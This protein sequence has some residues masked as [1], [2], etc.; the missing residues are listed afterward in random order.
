MK[1]ILII[2]SSPRQNGNCDI[3]CSEFG[4]GA[5]LNEGNEVQR[6][7]LRDL[8][9][10]F[11]REEQD[12]DDFDQVAQMMIDSDV[13]ALASPV[14]FY[15]MS[16]QMKT[17]MD[18]MMPYFS[19]VSDKDFYFILT[20]AIN[21]KEMQSAIDAMSGFTDSLPNANIVKVFLA[22]NISQKGEVMEKPVYREVFDAA[23]RIQ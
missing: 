20:S 16:G 13:I 23:A 17:M 9:Y 5:L 4:R 11:Y 15:T 12:K 10:D 7:D 3:L 18:R 6:V 22:P 14:Y 2:N 21:R 19:Q 8:T 1:K